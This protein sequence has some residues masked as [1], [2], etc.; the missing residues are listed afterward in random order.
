MIFKKKR[1]KR[2]SLVFTLRYDLY[3]KLPGWG[4]VSKPFSAISLYDLYPITLFIH[5]LYHNLFFRTETIKKPFAF[6][7]FFNSIQMTELCE[8]R[9]RNKTSTVV[10]AKSE[11]DVGFFLTIV[12]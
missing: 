2:L 12:M 8:T 5:N 6:R 11:S 7:F 1:S 10:P 4:G 9:I 3:A